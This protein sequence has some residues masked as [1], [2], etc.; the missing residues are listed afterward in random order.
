MA[1]NVFHRGEVTL[2]ITEGKLFSEGNLEERQRA[3]QENV[4]VMCPAP[5]CGQVRGRPSPGL[6]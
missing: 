1:R 4:H 5:L 3:N 2:D 6:L